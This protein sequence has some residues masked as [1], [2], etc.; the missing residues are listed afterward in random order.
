[1]P[2]PVPPCFDIDAIRCAARRPDNAA[3]VRQLCGDADAALTRP[4]PAVVDKPHPGPSGDPHDFVSFARYSWPDP[5]RPDGLPYINRDGETNPESMGPDSDRPRIERLGLDS[6]TLAL[7]WCCTGDERYARHAAA[8]LRRWFLDP[9]SRM[10]PH[11]EYAQIVRGHP[12]GRCFGVIDARFLIDAVQAAALIVGTGGWS[13]A[14]LAALRAWFPPYL[15]WL[16]RS[17]LGRE[18]AARHNN[19]GTWFDAQFCALALFVDD[20]ARA[21]AVLRQVAARR[22]DPQIRPD[23][24]MPHEL[25]RTRSFD[26]SIVNLQALAFLADLAQACGI[27]LWHHRGSEGQCLGSA[28]D[29]L[30]PYAHD[31]RAWPHPQLECHMPYVGELALILRRASRALGEA[32][33]EDALRRMPVADRLASRVDLVLPVG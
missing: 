26:Y 18:E 28:I 29:Y 4:A 23:G 27:D 14:D 2:K 19:H 1:M 17:R 12:G 25:K 33:Y 20:R 11:L 30:L 15:D 32:R 31:R 24:S 9:G 13:A 6:L 16:E 21:E 22:I 5:S 3:Q 10:N 7:A 8:Y